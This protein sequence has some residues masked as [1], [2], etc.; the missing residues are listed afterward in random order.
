ML[1]ANIQIG[2]ND[3]MSMPL[4]EISVVEND[5]VNYLFENAQEFERTMITVMM[6]EPSTRE[7]ISRSVA[8]INQRIPFLLLNDYR[9]SHAQQ[10]LRRLEVLK[11]FL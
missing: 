3:Q 5:L 10:S 6:D 9:L 2:W 11:G 4:K 8:R 7:S 1:R